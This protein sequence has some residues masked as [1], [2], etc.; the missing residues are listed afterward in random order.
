VGIVNI[1]VD[2]RNVTQLT[3]VMQRVG[4]LPEVYSVE[5]VVPH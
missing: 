3:A 4:Q 5:R 2:I 1:V